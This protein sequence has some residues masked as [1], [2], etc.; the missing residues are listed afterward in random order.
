[1]IFIFVLTIR[2]IIPLSILRFPLFGGVFSILVDTY[3]INLLSFFGWGFLDRD[4][5]QFYDKSLDTYYLFFEFLVV[6]G[7]KSG[8]FKKTLVFLFILRVIGFFLFEVTGKSLALFLFPNFFEPVYLAI[9]ALAKIRPEWIKYRIKRVLL[10]IFILLIL[11]M[12]QEYNL[13]VKRIDLKSFVL[14]KFDKKPI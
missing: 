6:T 3:D 8:F 14:E 7:I 9:I 1:M 2:L 4:Y 13:H 12:V 11:K 10:I 5:Y